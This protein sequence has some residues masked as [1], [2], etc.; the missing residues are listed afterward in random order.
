M[1]AICLL[2]ACTFTTVAELIVLC[3]P[4]CICVQTVAASRA[5]QKGVI[6]FFTQTPVPKK[7][8]ERRGFNDQCCC[9]CSHT[10]DYCTITMPDTLSS[11]TET[12]LPLCAC[13]PILI[14]LRGKAADAKI[15]SHPTLYIQESNSMRAPRV[16]NYV[17]ESARIVIRRI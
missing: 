2:N 16:L 14:R 6:V 7:I 11:E 1:S 17:C 5:K 12:R 10:L 8:Y 4:A 15:E 9:G 3:W 13:V